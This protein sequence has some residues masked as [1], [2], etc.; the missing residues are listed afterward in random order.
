MWPMDATFISIEM[1]HLVPR[2]RHFVRSG[3]SQVLVDRCNYASARC[4]RFAV[5]RLS[6]IKEVTTLGLTARKTNQ[7]ATRTGWFDRRGRLN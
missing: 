2:I 1:H 3:A 5:G 6:F 7:P 4:V